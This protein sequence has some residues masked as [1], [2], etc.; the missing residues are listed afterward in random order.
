MTILTEVTRENA[1]PKV[2]EVFDNFIAS[3]GEV[4]K[5][6]QVS[7][8]SPGLFMTQLAVIEYYRNSSNL[9]P[10]LLAYIRFLTADALN[11]QA[12]KV[13]NGRLLKL[14]GMTEEGLKNMIHD[15]EK[16]PLEDKEIELLKFVI[17]GMRGKKHGDK[18]DIS[19]LHNLGWSD[20]DIIDAVYQ[21]A[22][23]LGHNKMLEYFQV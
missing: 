14:Q 13:F 4:P 18:N 22:S 8:G 21:G 16:A 7:A 6:L 1:N 19:R 10:G 3:A 17:D 23:M 2:A 9:Q 20:S 5:P 15:F 11:Y 12:C